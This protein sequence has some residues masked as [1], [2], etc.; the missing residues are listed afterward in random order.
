M[1]F[2]NKKRIWP[3]LLIGSAII[4]GFFGY[5]V[6]RRV[7]DLTPDDLL[8]STFVQ[9]QIKSRVGESSAKIFDLAPDLLGYAKP[10]TIL[11]LFLNNTELRPGGGFIGSYAVVEVNKGK[12]K[13]LKV[14]GIE[15]LD[16]AANKENLLAPPA[17][18][19]AHLKVDKWFLRDSNWS[20]DFAES[21]KLA[22]DFYKRE[23]GVNATEIDTVVG[24]KPDVLEELL[25]IIGNVSVDGIE[26]TPENVVEKLEYEVEYGFAARGISFEERKNMLK[27]LT[28]AIVAKVRQNIFGNYSEYL[29]M[30]GNLGRER[31]LLIY[32]EDK[33]FESKIDALG[34][35]GKMAAPEGDYLLWVDANLTALKTDHALERTLSYAIAPDGQGNFTASAKMKYKHTGGFDWRTTRYF[36]YARVYAPI[37]SEL[38]SVSGTV[39]FGSAETDKPAFGE[40]SG[41]MW[42]GVFAS[43]APGQERELV[44]NYRLPPKISADI[45]AGKYNLFVQKQLGTKTY[46]LTLDLNFDKNITGA[47]TP[48]S[49]EQWGDSHYRLETK[50][51]TDRDFA[52]GL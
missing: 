49:K 11:V 30:A 21:A 2:N 13:I 20:P 27:K 14:E 10:R 36:T 22:L 25:K 46:G 37:G 35:S 24:V 32:S 18:M 1:F 50:L 5:L 9:K 16:N 7:A 17:I 52:V 45:V 34:W 43:L 42:F 41:K 12:S 15:T 40:E 28:D 44:F 33:N 6:F 38:V 19:K 48:E 29:T 31:Q 51:E 8:K 4:F 26:F 47:S 23:Q 3:Y 39:K